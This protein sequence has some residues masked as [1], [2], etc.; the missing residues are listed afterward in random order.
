MYP[1]RKV[2]TMTLIWLCTSFE[3]NH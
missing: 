3:G 1:Y 2:L